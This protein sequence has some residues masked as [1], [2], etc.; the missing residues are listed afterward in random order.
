MWTNEDPAKSGLTKGGVRAAGI[1]LSGTTA[2]KGLGA[3][4]Q[5]RFAGGVWDSTGSTPTHT[6]TAG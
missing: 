1:L 2:P 4:L 3:S 5:T 6:G